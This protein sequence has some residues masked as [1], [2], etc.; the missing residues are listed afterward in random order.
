M[1]QKPC[2]VFREFGAKLVSKELKR[3]KN[4]MQKIDVNFFLI[5]GCC[6]GLV[7]EG[8]FLEHDKDIDIGIFEDVNLE[9]LE[10]HLIH[11]GYLHVAIVGTDKGKY[12]WAMREFG[13][14]LL[15]FEI[16]VH[17]RKDNVVYFNRDLEAKTSP[18]GYGEG[19]LEWPAKLFETFELISCPRGEIYSVPSPV[20]E[21][22]AVQHGDWKTPVE[23]VDWRYHAKNIKKGWIF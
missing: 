9:E 19:R 16:Q 20:E 6:L 22:L 23:Y 10:I 17:Y 3:F 21:Y 12:M 18:T 4:L 15:V 7:R 11:S 1:E 2:G 8:K 14:T 13:K 5:G